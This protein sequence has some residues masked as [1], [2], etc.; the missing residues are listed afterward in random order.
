MQMRSLYDDEKVKFHFPQA[1]CYCGIAKQI[2]IDHLIPKIK[3]GADYS[4]NLV[5]A[6]KPCN[7]S[8]RDHDLIEWLRSKGKFPSILLLRRYTKLVARYCDQYGLLELPLAESLLHQLPFELQLLPYRF[9]DLSS[10]V[11][12]ISPYPQQSPLRLG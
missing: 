9:P 2:S 3:G 8:K 10:L 11:L 5:W 1:C 12:W 6:C 4:D 7:S